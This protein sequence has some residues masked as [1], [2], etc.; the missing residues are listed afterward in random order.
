VASMDALP[1][2]DTDCDTVVLAFPVTLGEIATERLGDGTGVMVV[3][4]AVSSALGLPVTVAL[5][6]SVWDG[7]AV[8]V[9]DTVPLDDGVTVAEVVGSPLADSVAVPEAVAEADRDAVDEPEALEADTVSE[10]L[11]VRLAETMEFVAD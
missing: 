9:P 8:A 7:E 3:S 11:V 2:D 5:S 1:D 6:D 10:K 4:V